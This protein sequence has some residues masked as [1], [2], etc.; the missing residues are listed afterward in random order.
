MKKA[1]FAAGCFWGVEATFRKING[2]HSSAV[3]YLGGGLDNPSYEDV[4]TGKTGHAE[5]VEVNYDPDVISY[6]DLLNIFW[7]CHNP[8]TLNQQGLDMGTQYRSAIFFHDDEQKTSAEA[9]MELTRSS[10]PAPIVTEI[11][12]TSTF[13]LA[14]EYHQQYI[15]RRR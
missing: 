8:T 7:E 6:S 5:V 12:P 4:C 10:W 9:S 13:Y 2:V 14:E 15:E 3:G 1:T 11:T